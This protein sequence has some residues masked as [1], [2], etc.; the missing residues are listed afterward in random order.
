MRRTKF[1]VLPIVLIVA[2]TCGGCGGNNDAQIQPTQAVLKLATTAPGGPIETID[3]TV[4]LPTGVSYRDSTPSGV[5][6]AANP[7]I[8]VN[9]NVPGRVH[10]AMITVAGFGVGEF[11]T[12]NCDIATGSTPSIADFLIVHFEATGSEGRVILN[13]LVPVISV[14]MR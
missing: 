3:V 11:F 12:M 13:G 6:V 5:A 8:A 14:E 1:A 9:P 7:L 4:Q 2:V 10:I